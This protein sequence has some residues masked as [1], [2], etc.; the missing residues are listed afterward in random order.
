MKTVFVTVGTTRF[1]ELISHIFSSGSLLVLFEKL[2]YT[3]LIIQHG[4]STPV[5]T[6]R[7]SGLCIQLFDYSNDLSS[8]YDR[9]DLVISHA[10]KFSGTCKAVLFLINLAKKGIWS[11]C[12]CINILGAGTILSCLK[13]KK[14]LIVVVNDKLMNNHQYELAAELHKQRYL[15]AST[16]T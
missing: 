6:P 13:Q 10:G 12:L 14:R 5:P 15:I 16:I 7:K 9:A 3:Q 8:Y 1:D 11:K 2:G 4:N